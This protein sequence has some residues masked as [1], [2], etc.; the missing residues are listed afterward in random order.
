MSF[1]YS[2][3]VGAIFGFIEIPILVGIGSIFII[4]S[5]RTVKDIV[6]KKDFITGVQSPYQFY[7]INLERLNK[8]KNKSALKY[9][10]QS[11]FTDGSIAIIVFFIIKFIK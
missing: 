7:L 11:F 2:I 10:A 4:V 8:T 1:I 9:F 5:F 3:I 6:F